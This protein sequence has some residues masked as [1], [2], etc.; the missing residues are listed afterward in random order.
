MITMR[1]LPN[2]RLDQIHNDLERAVFLTS[3]ASL[4]QRTLRLL[5]TCLIA[6]KHGLRGVLYVWPLIIL[7][8]IEFPEKWQWVPLA[9]LVLAIIAWF[10]FI[11]GSIRDD[12]QRFVNG[13]LL[14]FKGLK[15]V[16]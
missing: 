8:F 6:A 11:Y 14:E 7:I 3:Y 1:S 15:K 10:R 16:L 13:V 12:Y 9:L 5:A 4:K 2:K